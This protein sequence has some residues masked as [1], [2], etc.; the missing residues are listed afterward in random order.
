MADVLKVPYLDGDVNNWY[1][2]AKQ[3]DIDSIELGFVEGEREPVV[4]IQDDPR[5]GDVFTNDRITYKVRHEYGG[6]VTAFQGFDG[7]IVP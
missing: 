1:L 4:L 2:A 5:T 3:S 7:S 6:A